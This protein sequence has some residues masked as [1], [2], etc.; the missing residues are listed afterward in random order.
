MSKPVHLYTRKKGIHWQ[1]ERR[2]VWSLVIGFALYIIAVAA[3]TGWGDSYISPS[4]VLRT[5]FGSGQGEYDFIIMTL[6]L[7]RVL[8]ALLVGS[9]LGVSGA[10]LQG[11]IR[12]P[13]A[14]PDIIGITGGATAA[15]VTFITFL[16]GSVSIKLLPVAAVAGALLVSL[17]VY[18]LSWQRGVTPIRL[19]LIGIGLSAAAKAATTLMIVMGPTILASKAYLWMTGSVYGA[20]WDNVYTV[21]PAVLIG[22]PLAL[23]F[24]RSLNAQ[25]LGDDVAGSL[26]VAVQRHRFVLVLISVVLAGFAVSVAGAIGFIGLIAPHLARR[27]TGR[28]FGG[29]LLMSALTGG[30]LVFLADLIARTVFYPLDIPAGVFTA[31]IGAPF[32][33]YMLFRNRNQL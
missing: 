15:A 21:L 13:L 27:W 3:G 6:R 11:V 16:T 8:T 25:E 31:G 17:L 24:A 5:I 29:L 28:M 4:D 12:N 2:T 20:S 32:F 19:V 23:Y 30:L 14:S 7:P 18:S 10:I 1:V 22:I 9:A 33:I 26:G